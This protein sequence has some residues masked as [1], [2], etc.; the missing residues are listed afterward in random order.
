MLFAFI[1]FAICT[2]S[3]ITV[4]ASPNPESLFPFR[5]TKNYNGFKVKFLSTNIVVTKA[6]SLL[7]QIHTMVR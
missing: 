3:C 5:R 1:H 4:I 6:F 7:S 2:E